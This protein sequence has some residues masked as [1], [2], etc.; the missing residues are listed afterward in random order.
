MKLA[1]ILSMLLIV[2]IGCSPAQDS[3]PG[4]PINKTSA[5]SKNQD[6]ILNTRDLEQLGMTGDDCKTEEYPTNEYSPL[7]QYSFCNY[8]IS[9]LNDT[10]VVMELKKFTNAHDRNGSYQYESLHLSS[11]EGLISENEFGDMS[12]FRVSNEN[13]YGGQFNGPNVTY[14]HLY[15]GK[16]EYLIHI[17]SKGSKGAGEYIGKIGQRIMSKFG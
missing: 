16:D 10:E 14:Y 8:T 6:L 1:I 9:S 13:D 7:A 2:I 3:Q 17:T 5:I 15:I 11:S 12:R 4:P